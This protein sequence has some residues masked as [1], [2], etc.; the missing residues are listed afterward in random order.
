MTNLEIIGS[1]LAHRVEVIKGETVSIKDHEF[2]LKPVELGMAY[3]EGIAVKYKD[4]S[5]GEESR[6]VTKRLDVKVVEPIAGE[7]GKARKR[8]LFTLMG[9]FIIALGSATFALR[10]KIFPKREGEKE[11]PRA[12]LEERY[13]AELKSSV[14][15]NPP[16]LKDSFSH[17]SRLC[18]RYLAEKYS[19]RTMEVT[20]EETL[21]SLREAEPEERLVSDVEDIL[22]VCDLAK[23]AAGEGSKADLERAYTKFESILEKNL[24]EERKRLAQES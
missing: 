24:I 9:V 10:R 23:F 16:D 13:L 7:G 6:L 22:R 14:D 2:I 11:E 12:L 1:S 17:L 20:T 5:T 19:I 3:V 21:Q 8:L 18:R 15:L 4:T